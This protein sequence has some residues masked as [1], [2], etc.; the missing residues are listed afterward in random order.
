M[1]CGGS[2]CFGLVG[3]AFIVWPSASA[4]TWASLPVVYGLQGLG[5]ATFESTNRALMSSFFPK[6]PQTE[7]IFSNV[8]LQN[9]AANTAFYFLLGAFPAG[10]SGFA[11]E[12]TIASTGALAVVATSAAVRLHKRRR[13]AEAENAGFTN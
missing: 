7:A 10:G 8:I 3:A 2:V 9:G 13:C 1:L 6:S 12:Y 11:Y 5:R 4:W